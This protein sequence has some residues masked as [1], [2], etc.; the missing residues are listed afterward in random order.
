VGGYGSIYY[1]IMNGSKKKYIGINQRIPFE[2]LERAVDKHLSSGAL[3][4]EDILAGI[5]SVTSGNNRAKKAAMYAWQII[6]RQTKVLN[7]ISKYHS[8]FKSFRA[9]EKK[10]LCLFLICLTYPIA[11][12]LLVAMAQGL[13]VQDV[14]N[15]KFMTSKISAL[16]GSNRT[17]DVAMDAII[18]MLVELGVIQR[19]KLGLYGLG[20]KLVIKKAILFEV[21]TFTDA[22]VQGTKSLLLDTLIQKPWYAYFDVEMSDLDKPSVMFDRK[23]SHTGK[24]Y[25]T[26]KSFSS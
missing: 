22:T 2:V 13:K 12:D 17:V 14:V 24:G 6:N 15:K 10:A 5:K 4:K 21:L 19:K 8:S 23:D 11:Y 20:K 18:P 7:Q 25:L 3:D 9:D 1:Y 26:V 16:Y